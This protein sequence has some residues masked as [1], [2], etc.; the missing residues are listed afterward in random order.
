MVV[1]RPRNQ[2]KRAENV[3]VSGPFRPYSPA[4]RSK[5]APS[6]ATVRQKRLA[7]LH[8]VSDRRI[9]SVYGSARIE[10]GSRV[11][12]PR[13]GRHYDRTECVTCDSAASL[14]GW[15]V[16]VGPTLLR[17]R[18]AGLLILAIALPADVCPQTARADSP[19]ELPARYAQLPAGRSRSGPTGVR[20]CPA[21]SES[22]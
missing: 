14:E 7:H 15:L 20:G 13:I 9:L 17:F 6:S 11:N 10:D 16:V 19:S 5:G 3:T 4:P 1:A 18:L 21:E 2:S 8:R 22:R 12:V